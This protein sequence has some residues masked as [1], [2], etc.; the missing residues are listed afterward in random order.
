MLWAE[1]YLGNFGVIRA[2]THLP[3]RL[4]G[5]QQQVHTRLQHLE[6]ERVL[7][8]LAVIRGGLLGGIGDCVDQLSRLG[9]SFFGLERGFQPSADLLAYAARATRPSQTFLKLLRQSY[10][11]RRRRSIFVFLFHSSHMTM[12]TE[13]VKDDL[14]YDFRSATFCPV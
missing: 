13:I 11:K 12:E 4:V 7:N 1:E 8:P 5:P 2:W 10:C 14:F 9:G 6:G 3:L